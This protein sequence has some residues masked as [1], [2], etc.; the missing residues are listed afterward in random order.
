M[1]N[2]PGSVPAN[3]NGDGIRIGVVQARFNE[4]ITDGLWR[5]CCSELLRLGV[6]NEDILHVT[7]PGAMEIP[8]TLQRLALS[9]EFDA[10]I[11]L[12]AVIKGDTYH[13]EI[14]CEESARGIA[15]IALAHD[16][17]VVNMV[18]TTYTEDQAIERIED[19]GV[20][21]A[22]CAVEMGNLMMTLDDNL[23]GADEEDDDD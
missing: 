10:L 5:A 12:G 9:G 18:L 2:S 19:K 15:N 7:V 14:V 3:L 20:D 13:F 6:L 4:E 8:L 11:A 17:P 16:V 22:R 23:P 1:S 21:A